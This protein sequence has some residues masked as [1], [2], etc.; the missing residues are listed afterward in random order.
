MSAPGQEADQIRKDHDEGSADGSV[1]I[2]VEGEGMRELPNGAAADPRTDR[3]G[4][5]QREACTEEGRQ[6]RES[7]VAALKALLNSRQA[8]VE[9]S[10]L[11]DQRY[12]FDKVTWHD[13]ALHL[14]DWDHHDLHHTEYQCVGVSDSPGDGPMYKVLEAARQEGKGLLDLIHCL[15]QQRRKQ[16][17]DGSKKTEE[18]LVNFWQNWNLKQAAEQAC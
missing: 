5:Q 12:A 11:F 10:R 4:V 16:G 1:V 6:Q 7:S 3:D 15:R 8:L 2:P 17:G 9:V 13:L 18:V 14:L